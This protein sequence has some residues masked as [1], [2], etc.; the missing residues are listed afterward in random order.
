MIASL[1]LLCNGIGM[2]IILLKFVD[3]ISKQDKNTNILGL[4]LQLV[5]CIN[6]ISEIKFH[7]T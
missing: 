3:A 4:V 1:S 2:I 5:A 6:F 7:L